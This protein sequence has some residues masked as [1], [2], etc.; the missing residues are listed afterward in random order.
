MALRL[1]A[2]LPSSL[3][4]QSAQI[5][6]QILHHESFLNATR[7]SIYVSMD[8]G[9]VQTEELCRKALESGK[10]LY[11]PRFASS[12][13]ANGKFETDMKMLRVR[14]WDDFQAMVMNRWGIREPD[15]VVDGRQREDGEQLGGGQ[16]VA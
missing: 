16:K 7:V 3:A 14:D 4:L 2:I 5:T 12:S 11:V 1:D 9:E 10:R 15:E 6:A 8:K 13:A